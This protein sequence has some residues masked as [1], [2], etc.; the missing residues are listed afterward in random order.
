MTKGSKPQLFSLHDPRQGAP[1]V[2]VVIVQ[3]GI[4]CRDAVHVDIDCGCVRGLGRG[5]SIELEDVES[6][7]VEVG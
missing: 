4:A 5:V 6:H 7:S 3:S 1:W 2:V